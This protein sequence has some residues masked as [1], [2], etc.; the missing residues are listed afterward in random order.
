MKLPAKLIFTIIALGTF[1]Q[2]IQACTCSEH[3]VPVCAEFDRAD[4]V[5]YGKV[6][7]VTP[8][9]AKDAKVSFPSVNSISTFKGSGLVWIHVKVEKA[10]KGVTE[11]TVKVATYQRTSCDIGEVKKGQRWIFFAYRNRESGILGVGACNATGQLSEKLSEYNDYFSELEKLGQGKQGTLVKG[12]II[13]DAF[14]GEPQ[15]ASVSIEGENFFSTNPTDKGGNFSFKV[16]KAGKYK[17]RVSV[18]FSATFYFTYKVT[19]FTKNSPT[20]QETIFEYEIDAEENECNYYQI[21]TFPIDLKATAIISGKFIPRDWKFFSKFY[22]ELCRLKETE[23]ETL[24]S[25]YSIYSLKMDGSF[26]IKGLR[27]GKYTL[28]INDGNF[29]DGSNPFWRHYYPGVK[30]FK[31][32]Q[33]IFLEQGQTIS[34]VKFT[35]PEFLPLR[36]IKG[37]VF[38][39]DG[40]PV[41]INPET[42]NNLFVWL[43]SFEKPDKMIFLHSFLID[44]E[45]KEQKSIEMTSVKPDGTFTITAF[46]GFTYWLEAFIELPNGKTKCGFAKLKMDE[47][48]IQPIKIIL[49]R[50]D[51]CKTEDYVKEL[52]KKSKIK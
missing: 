44:W 41:T 51:N 1:F 7:D 30:N 35:L 31:E 8:F 15:Q 47:A 50:T 42:D 48:T 40:K 26:E 46:D 23:E 49:D 10:F 3:G 17:V 12:T 21:E 36:E 52:E 34:D 19:N 11:K 25:C 28:V 22:P 16:P 27:E 9:E 20:E 45:S 4:A 33:P 18:P 2:S 38:W 5:F 43:Y 14:V 6:E 29:P 32:A 37:Q 13:K 39:K 24:K